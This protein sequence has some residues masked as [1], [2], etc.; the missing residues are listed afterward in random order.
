MESQETFQLFD[1]KRILIGEGIPYGF[2]L[3]VVLRAAVMF[4]AVL[5]ILRLS[6]KRGI[7]QLSIFELAIIIS[8]GSAAG[9]PMLYEDVAILPAVMVFVTV[10]GLYKFITTLTGKFEKV[11]TYLE[12]KPVKLIE[13]GKINYKVFREESLAYD[14]L[15]SQLRLRN[16][17]HLGQVHFAY[18]ETSGDLSVFYYADELVKLGLPILPETYDHPCSN[19]SSDQTYACTHCGEIQKNLVHKEKCSICNHEEWIEAVDS[20]RLA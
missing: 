6:G 8:L 2:L 15:F 17:S 19:F 14:E 5:L 1:L 3:E 7:K 4:F 10:I 20:K 9:D 11:E 12:G 13:H 18:L 16:V